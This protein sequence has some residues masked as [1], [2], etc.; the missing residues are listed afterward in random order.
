MRLVLPTLKQ[1]LWHLVAAG[2][3]SNGNCSGCGNSSQDASPLLCATF[4]R[5]GE[6]L[7]AIVFGWGSFSVPGHQKK[8]VYLRFIIRFFPSTYGANAIWHPYSL[9]GSV[10]LSL[11]FQ[12]N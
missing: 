7:F 8:H 3:G 2:S 11:A 1:P 12:W 5:N 6:F 4:S 10:W 9:L